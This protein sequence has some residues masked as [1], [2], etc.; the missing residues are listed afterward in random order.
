MTVRSLLSGDGLLLPAE[1][2]SRLAA[3]PKFDGLDALET[4]RVYLTLG[5]GAT[6]LY[7]CPA[8]KRARTGPG[9]V[10]LHNNTAL[11]VTV[12]LYHVPSGGATASTNKMAATVTVAAGETR[13]Y[14]DAAIRH[15][16]A[17]GESIVANTGGTGLNAWMWALE[18]RAEVCAFRGGFVG[19]LGITETTI[20]TV[21]A[22]AI[23]AL[24]SL[25]AYN[26][27]AGTRVLTLH[28]RESG[29]AAGTA[30]Q[31][32]N[33]SLLTVTGYTLYAALLPMLGEAGLVSGLGDIAGLNVWVNG[34]LIA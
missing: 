22:M 8:R 29:V 1:Y 21:P 7:T 11:G 16:L 31:I 12:E 14:F 6:T 15:V 3:D 32:E 24:E 18:E 25:V 10:L 27:T 13:L 2:R 23:F 17:A 34:A 4:R 33:Q 20:F 9:V 5:A 19:N 30:N 26:P 28:L